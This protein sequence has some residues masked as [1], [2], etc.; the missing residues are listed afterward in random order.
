MTGNRDAELSGELHRSAAVSGA[1]PSAGRRRLRGF[2]FGLSALVLGALLG[3]AP[4]V[5]GQPA[6][7][8]V[9]YIPTSMEVVRE[10]LAL[11]RVGAGDVL[12][13]LG[14]GDGRI[15]I[16]A[17]Q[18]FGTRGIGFEIVPELIVRSRDAAAAA[19]VESLVRFVN[20]DLFTADLSPASLVTLYLS[21]EMNVRL[22]PKLLRELKAGARVVS[23]GFH[24]GDW[25]PDSV[26]H[27]GEGFGQATVYMWVV[28]VAIDGFWELMLETPGGE[29]WYVLEIDQRYQ[30]LAGGTLKD[31]R[32]FPLSG[33]RI[34][35]ESLSFSF[36][37]DAGRRPVT[38]QLTGRMDGTIL[39]GQVGSFT[40]E[41]P[42]R[43]RATRFRR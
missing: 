3:V 2:R 30:E 29:R 7:E 23:H 16:V 8:L 25:R 41:G 32:S 10:M 19:G 22:R 31:G 33:G 35:G 20:R 11:G 43:W 27:V 18:R 42:Y 38:Y 1:W 5:V 15:P 26:V 34:R 21:P 6:P 17:A 4:S 12:F 9:P 37:D 28:P 14:S 39:H 24:M 40:G 36:R 13:D